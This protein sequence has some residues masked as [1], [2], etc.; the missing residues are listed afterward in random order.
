M[1]WS[2]LQLF[3]HKD[4]KLVIGILFVSAFSCFVSFAIRTAAQRGLPLQFQATQRLAGE[5]GFL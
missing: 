5:I 4:T 1:L 2:V 3:G